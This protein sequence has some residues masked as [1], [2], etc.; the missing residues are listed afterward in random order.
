MYIG[1]K[2]ILKWSVNIQVESMW[3]GFLWLRLRTT[4]DTEERG[5]KSYWSINGGISLN[6]LSQESQIQTVRGP[7]AYFEI[8]GEPHVT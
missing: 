8:Y 6:C 2:I 7:D 5:N 3:P 1:G 4:G